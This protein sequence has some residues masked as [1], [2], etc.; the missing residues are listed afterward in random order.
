MEPERNTAR[1]VAIDGHEA[2]EIQLTQGRVTLV[3]PEDWPTGAAHR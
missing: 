2:V 3:D 1:V